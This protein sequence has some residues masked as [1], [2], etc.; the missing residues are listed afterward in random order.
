M[1]IRRG[2]QL[3]QHHPETVAG[4][5]PAMTVAAVDFGDVRNHATDRNRIQKKCAKDAL[6]HQELDGLL[7]EDGEGRMRAHGHGFRR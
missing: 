5:S 7:D 3:R 4:A 1:S 2:T 6:A